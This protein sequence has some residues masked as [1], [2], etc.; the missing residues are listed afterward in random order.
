GLY[1]VRTHISGE[2]AKKRLNIPVSAV[3]EKD[4]FRHDELKLRKKSEASSEERQVHFIVFFS[5]LKEEIDSLVGQARNGRS[6]RGAIKRTF[7]RRFPLELQ[8]SLNALEN[9]I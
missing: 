3:E 6:T 7:L 1:N 8:L 2:T 9:N 4:I 5:E